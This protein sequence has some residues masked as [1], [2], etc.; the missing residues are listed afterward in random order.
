M[1]NVKVSETIVCYAI[2]ELWCILTLISLLCVI[3]C[4]LYNL[5]KK[6]VKMR[7]AGKSYIARVLRYLTWFFSEIPWALS[8]DSDSTLPQYFQPM[9]TQLQRKL[10]SHWLIFLRQRHVA[11]VRQGPEAF[12]EIAIGGQFGLNMLLGRNDSMRTH[13]VHTRQSVPVLYQHKRILRP[14]ST[15]GGSRQ[16]DTAQCSIH[17]ESMVTN[18]A[19]HMKERMN[20]MTGHK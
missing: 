15:Y 14:Q 16:N 12:I 19:Q 2:N 8:Y 5:Y 18:R 17:L 7:F 20:E 1:H 3:S 10:S 6:E 9:T 13:S 4:Y 11:V